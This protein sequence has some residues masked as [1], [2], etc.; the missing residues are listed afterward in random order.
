ILEGSRQKLWDVMASYG[1][2]YL[3]HYVNF[4]DDEMKI[5]YRVIVD[6]PGILSK[7][8]E[9]IAHDFKLI[10]D[11]ISPE[12]FK[13]VILNDEQKDHI[14]ELA[15]WVA[16]IRAVSR[17]P[18]YYDIESGKWRQ[19]L[20]HIQR[21]AP[22]RV[23]QQLTNFVKANVLLRSLEVIDEKETLT[24]DDHAMKLAAKLA[25]NSAPPFRYKIIREISKNDSGLPL[26]SL[27][28][29]LG[30][31]PEKH[32][33]MF[34]YHVQPLVHWGALEKDDDGNYKLPLAIHSIFKKYK[35]LE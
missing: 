25:M 2:R 29:A 1:S 28:T 3:F 21:E 33:S 31:D 26:S 8:K 10:M 5:A 30:Y 20:V 16:S 24:V 22:L 17:R 12:M 32:K 15:K 27:C 9:A 35:V 6:A 23:A 4:D 19:E 34:Y 11:L 13:K 14:W 7:V 18:S